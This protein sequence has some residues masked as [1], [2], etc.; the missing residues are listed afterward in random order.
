MFQDAQL[1]IHHALDAK[2]IQ[3]LGAC[4]PDTSARLRI[5][6]FVKLQGELVHILELVCTDKVG[7]NGI[8]LVYKEDSGKDIIADNFGK[9]LQGI[10]GQPV[11]V[12]IAVYGQAVGHTLDTVVVQ[13]DFASACH[14]LRIPTASLQGVQFYHGRISILIIPPLIHIALGQVHLGNH[15]VCQDFCARKSFAGLRDDIYDRAGAGAATQACKDMDGGQAGV[16]GHLL[17][18]GV[19]IAQAVD[20]A[21]G[22]GS[23]KQTACTALL[24][25]SL[26][27]RTDGRL[28]GSHIVHDALHRRIVVDV[29]Q[30]MLHVHSLDVQKFIVG[31]RCVLPHHAEVRPRPSV[32]G[33]HLVRRVHIQQGDGQ[34]APLFLRRKFLE[35][36]HFESTQDFTSRTSQA[37]QNMVA[38]A[39]ICLCHD[40]MI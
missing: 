25:G 1:R 39:K 5:S 37:N 23:K 24:T 34:L 18:T 6:R 19:C 40:A 36:S 21:N 3:L 14:I 4:H 16:A 8:F 15:D 20:I 13:L 31:E 9:F 2:G 33:H 22:V 17:A 12:D 28:D 35:H 11:V 27:Q 7:I 38:V 32:L 10:D 26:P 29:I 30:D